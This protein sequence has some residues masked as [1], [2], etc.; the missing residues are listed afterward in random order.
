MTAGP[1]E[2][3]LSAVPPARP[4]EAVELDGWLVS[5]RPAQSPLRLID[6]S[7]VAKLVVQAAPAGVVAEQ[8]AVPVG[9]TE[10]FEDGLLA[11]CTAPGEWLV[12]CPGDPTPFLS[13]LRSSAGDEATAV[14]DVT[15]GRT[16][17]RLTGTDAGQLLG[18]L[19]EVDL[20]DR[21]FPVGSA[22]YAPLAGV[23]TGILRDDLFADEAGWPVPGPP[24]D[25]TATAARGADEV[26]EADEADEPEAA[27]ADRDED[28]VRSY[29]LHCDRS[30]GRYLYGQLLGA[31][32]ERG[33]EEEGYALHRARRADL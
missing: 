22:T 7:P 11:A 1:R 13:G 8:L 21:S 23:R 19:C 16:L 30:A 2:P 32:A 20:S 5:A 29:L 10:L 31:G 26:D 9:R 24:A 3:F 18:E 17:L 27:G 25:H 28:E 12:L 6:C 15:Q 33:I 14:L 4:P